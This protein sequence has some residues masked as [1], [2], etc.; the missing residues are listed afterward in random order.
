MLIYSYV[1]EY[2]CMSFSLS[3]PSPPLVKLPPTPPLIRNLE[4]LKT[5]SWGDFLASFFIHLR[6][7]RVNSLYFRKN[8]CLIQTIE[9]VSLI[10][11]TRLVKFS[12]IKNIDSSFLEIHRFMSLLFLEFVCHHHVF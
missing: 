2:N 9:D 5:F 10:I 3:Q 6:N 12:T 4:F 11:K 7:V 8:E 1:V